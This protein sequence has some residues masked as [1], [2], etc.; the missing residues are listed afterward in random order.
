[1][2]SILRVVE[3]VMGLWAIFAIIRWDLRRGELISGGS[4]L[5]AIIMLEI[6]I[7]MRLLGIKHDSLGILISVAISSLLFSIGKFYYDRRNLI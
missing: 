3:I 4:Q 7:I 6:V 5:S 1:M 2:L